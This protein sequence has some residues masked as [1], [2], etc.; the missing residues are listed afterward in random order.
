MLGPTIDALAAE[1]GDEAVIAKVNVDENPDI[2]QRFNVNAIPTIIFFKKG[3][4]VGVSGMAPKDV[5]KAKLK[6]IK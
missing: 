2:A 5:L 3:K 6:E 4:M 1:I